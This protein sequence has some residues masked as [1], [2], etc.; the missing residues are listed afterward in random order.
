[1]GDQQARLGAAFPALGG[2]A[3]DGGQ[4]GQIHQALDV[5]G[6]GHRPPQGGGDEEDHQGE[7]QAQGG[8]LDGAAEPGVG[9]VRRVRQGGLLVHHQLRLAQDQA[10]HLGI[11]VDDGA[12]NVVGVL[13]IGAFHRQDKEAG[14]L[15][16]GGGD[17]AVKIGDAQPLQQ[18]LLHAVGGQQIGEG[19]RHLLGGGFVVILAVA[20]EVGAAHKAEIHGEHRLGAVHGAEAAVAA[21]AHQGGAQHDQRQAHGP[22]PP[23]GPEHPPQQDGQVDGLFFGIGMGRMFHSA[24]HCCF[25][26]ER[27]PQPYLSYFLP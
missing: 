18:Q 16:G 24:P 20:G 8:A 21:P 14:V 7:R 12:E 15:D 5:A 19:V 17:D 11:H 13:G 9:V 2:R 3:G 10:V 25:W 1:M 22:Q 27:C 6:G 23:Q 4:A 26:P